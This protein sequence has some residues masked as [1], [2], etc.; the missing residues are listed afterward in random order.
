MVDPSTY[1]P[2]TATWTASI[3]FYTYYNRIWS[4]TFVSVFAWSYV[5]CLDMYV[6][7]TYIWKEVFL[8]VLFLIWYLRVCFG[9]ENITSKADEL[10]RLF[11]PFRFL[12][13]VFLEEQTQ[14]LYSH[15]TFTILELHLEWQHTL[16]HYKGLIRGLLLKEVFIMKPKLSIRNS[17]QQ[18]FFTLSN[19]RWLWRQNVAL[20][21]RCV[22]SEDSQDLVCSSSL[23]LPNL[24]IRGTISLTGEMKCRIKGNVAQNRSHCIIPSS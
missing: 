23:E 17:T 14:T 15:Q 5:L 4:D 24:P 2:N 10:C 8:L 20:C 12:H 1:D 7:F 11:L 9:T 3:I 19:Y 18:R 22:R 13:V 6:M 21:W 16:S